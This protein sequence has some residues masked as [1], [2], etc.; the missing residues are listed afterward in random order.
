MKKN[1]VQ[2]FLEMLYASNIPRIYIILFLV[3]VWNTLRMKLNMNSVE[4]K[5]FYDV[6]LSRISQH[7]SQRMNGSIPS[8]SQQIYMQQ[9]QQQPLFNPPP[10]NPPPFNQAPP[11]QMFQ[12]QPQQQQFQQQQ[13]QINQN[14]PQFQPPQFQ[15]PPPPQDNQQQQQQQNMIN[16]SFK[17]PFQ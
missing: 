2:I 5:N 14:P 9:Q 3:N 15:P 11:P 4:D 13:N 7:L 1:N 6:I 17:P 8:S 16:S 12:Q 10:F